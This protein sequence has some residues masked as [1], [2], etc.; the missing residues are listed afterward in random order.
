MNNYGGGG[1][2]F[3]VDVTVSL[4]EIIEEDGEA[5]IRMCQAVDS[6]QLTDVTY[7]Y[8]KSLGTFGN[9]LPARE[10]FPALSNEIWTASRIHAANAGLFTA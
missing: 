2:P 1:K 9:Q 6:N 10:K 3:D 4:D 5:V 7:N 8:L